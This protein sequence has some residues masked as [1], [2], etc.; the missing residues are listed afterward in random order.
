MKYEYRVTKYDPRLRDPSDSYTGED[1]TSIS[2]VGQSFAGRK[3][4]MRDYLRAEK[5]YLAV[6]SAMLEEAKVTR[7]RLL[8][9]ENAEAGRQAK[10]NRWREGAILSLR[11]ATEFARLALR[12]KLWGMLIAPR[13]AFVHFGYDYYMYVGLSRPTP[14]A[15]GMAARVG[16]FVEPYRSPYSE[17]SRHISRRPQQNKHMR[18]KIGGKMRPGNK[19]HKVHP[20][21]IWWEIKGKTIDQLI[22]ELRTFSDQKAKIRISIDGGDT[23]YPISML[24]NFNTTEGRTPGIAFFPDDD[25]M[26]YKLRGR[27]PAVINTDS[28]PIMKPKV[29][30]RRTARVDKKR[31]RSGKAAR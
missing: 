26:I 21:R 19:P 29:R 10:R 24:G 16:I 18:I 3:L 4:T 1:W 9:L 28:W 31:T 30:R 25:L 8:G 7:L 20:R 11:Q 27:S 17:A 12:E 22:S 14:S 6:M 13:R 5:N 2:Q 23:L 15:L